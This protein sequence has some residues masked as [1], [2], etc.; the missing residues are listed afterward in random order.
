MDKTETLLVHTFYRFRGL[1]GY[2]G[3]ESYRAFGEFK[4][5][6]LAISK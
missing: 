6:S 1:S 2:L 5:Q 4:H 3:V